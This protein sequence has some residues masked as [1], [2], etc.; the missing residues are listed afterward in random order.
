MSN[1]VWVVKSVKALPDFNLFITFE[2]GEK[3]SLILSL[4]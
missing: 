3:N 2:S 1:P 4:I